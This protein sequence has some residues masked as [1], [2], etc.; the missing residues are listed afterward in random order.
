[1][2]VVYEVTQTSTGQRAA[3]KLLGAEGCYDEEIRKRFLLEARHTPS[4][5]SEHIVRVF[6]A[7]IT[8]GRPWILMELLDGVTLRELVATCGSLSPASVRDIMAQLCHGLGG[9]H[10]R[11]IV[12]RDVKPDNVFVCQSKS[13]RG[14]A[15]VK[16]LDFGVA[17]A[18]TAP[19]AATPASIVVGTAGWWAPEQMMAGTVSPSADVW[20]LG[21]LAYW[22]LTGVEYHDARSANATASA[23]EQARGQGREGAIPPGF[24]AWF[25]RCVAF[26]PAA[27]FVDAN[28]AWESLRYHLDHA[29]AAAPYEPT[30][31]H[32]PT[33]FAPPHAPTR[34]VPAPTKPRGSG[35]WILV[36]VLA[37]AAVGAVGAFARFGPV[38]VTTRALPSRTEVPSDA[39]DAVAFVRAW[40]E[41]RRDARHV[42]PY[43]AAQVRMNG[44]R[45]PVMPSDLEDY[46]RSFA[47][48][49]GRLQ[50]DWGAAAVTTEAPPYSRDVPE[51]CR[52]IEGADPTVTRVEASAVEDNTHSQTRCAHIEARYLF[53]LLRVGGRFAICHQTY[54]KT[55]L[56]AVCPRAPG[57]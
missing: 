48:N 43:Y 52:S 46:W 10:A 5:V 56:C 2:G 15:L 49:G 24:D 32:A 14:G 55:S 23:Y 17:K 1:M 30:E 18:L 6:D 9:A 44:E 29:R 34:L 4:D 11:G 54:V 26:D 12:H 22:M 7:D 27:R 40:D 42:A 31:V 37:A 28:A 19:R 53:R 3:L 45:S 16:L 41:A 33:S 8:D 20:A 39:T 25:A 13:A 21:L 36:A 51:T 38:D 50:F 57:C 47:D 35:R